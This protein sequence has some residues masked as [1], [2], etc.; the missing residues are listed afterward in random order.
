M[1]SFIVGVL[2]LS[3]LV[4]IHELGH[5]LAAKSLKIPVIAFSIGFGKPL[6]KFTKGETEYRLCP[7]PFGG[8]VQMEG[9]A[10]VESMSDSDAEQPQDGFSMRPIW[11]RAVVAVAGPF[12]NVATA[13]M[14]FWLMFVIGVPRATYL[15]NP[16]IGYVT[17]ESPLA[18]LL[19][20][21]DS[22]VAVNGDTITTFD[23]IMKQFAN[24]NGTYEISFYRGEKLTTVDV[25]IPAPDPSDMAS[26]D[27][28]IRALF[29]AIIGD[30]VVEGSPAAIAGIA[31]GDTIIA[32]NAQPVISWWQLQ[33]HVYNF[34]P[35]DTVGNI[36]TKQVLVVT[37]RNGSERM[38]IVTPELIED[39]PDS[40]KHY[41]MGVLAQNPQKYTQKFG[42]LGSISRAFTEAI[43][44]SVQM[45]AMLGRL[46]EGKVSVKQFSGPVG[47]MQISG[48]AAFAGWYFLLNILGVLSLNLGLLNL[49]PLV[50]TDG[51]ILMFLVVEKVRGKA[52]SALVQQKMSMV[53]MALFFTLFI[54]VTFNDVLR[55]KDLMHLFK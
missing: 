34:K 39:T 47:I 3:L 37:L 53:I 28:G 25:V 10:V 20:P 49:L 38:V 51:G 6:I 33:D 52:V 29:P 2:V 23:G 31:T 12:F 16:T 55:F 32:I 19:A 22:V 9:E 21:G 35:V 50:I 7:I 40:L 18:G 1:I 11:Q 46:F 17:K 48:A 41:R 54:V 30:D 42:I 27:V 45:G 24:L 4:F 8:Y 36:V 44:V 13:I 5:F 14:F 43:D 15:D 26:M